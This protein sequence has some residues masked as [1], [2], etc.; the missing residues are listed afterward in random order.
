MR[1]VQRYIRLG[2]SPST[3]NGRV[4]A[5]RKLLS[6][7][8]RPREIPTGGGWKRLL[9]ENGIDPQ[10]LRRSQIR[11]VPKA[12]SARGLQPADVIAMVEAKHFLVRLWLMLQWH[13]GLRPKE[14]V[15]LDPEES[16][17]GDYLLVLHGTKNKRKRSVDFSKN[18][19]RRAAQRSSVERA[20]LLRFQLDELVGA[21]LQRGEDD[22]L[23]TERVRLQHAEKLLGL[24][25]TAEASVYSGDNAAVESI[26]RALTIIREA[27]RVDDGLAGP[28]VLL[29]SALAEL[30]EASG[31]LTRYSRTLHPDPR[32]LETIDERLATAVQVTVE[33]VARALEGT[34]GTAPVPDQAE[35]VVAGGGRKNRALMEE[36]AQR[37]A[38]RTVVP[39]DDHGLDGDFKEAVVFAVLAWASA[40]GRPVNLPS[41][42]G[43]RHPA[44]C[45]RLSF[46]P[47]A[48]SRPA[49]G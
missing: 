13:F 7:L 34:C 45:G 6:L 10:V 31:A 42:T 15:E 35:V 29:E 11:V 36:L 48:G 20:E 39:V 49:A 27:E 18:P 26:G 46:P 14:C 19:E 17:R 4:T 9:R 41:V 8:G 30:E 24:V 40:L 3:I 5:L 22:S 44:R 38:P 33:S 47:A 37:L 2:K 12:V 1:L 16:D 21:K 25:N 28:R 23:A 43:A 32:R